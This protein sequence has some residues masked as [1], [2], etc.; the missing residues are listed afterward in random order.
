MLNFLKKPDFTRLV[1][2]N[3]SVRD[4]EKQKFQQTAN[5]ETVAKLSLK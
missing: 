4:T 3:K 1:R 5:V 2:F